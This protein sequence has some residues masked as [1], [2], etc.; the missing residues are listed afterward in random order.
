MTAASP[1]SRRIIVLGSTGSIGVNTL[2]VIE[3]LNRAGTADIQ[4][5]GL[6]AGS[7]A[8][9]LIEQAKRFGVKHVAIADP[10]Q[11]ETVTDALSDATV[12]SGEGSALGLVEEVEATDCAAAIV[13]AAGLPSTLAAIRHGLTIHLSNKETL[14]A[15]G[16]LVRP[17]LDRYGATLIPVD[18]EHSAIFQC[19]GGRPKQQIKR[20]VLTGSGGPFRTASAS[21][22][23][24]ATVEQALQHPTWNMGPKITIDSATL[25]N[26][27]L[28]LIEAHWLF[29]LPGEKIDLL[30]HPESVVHSFV[31]FTDHSILAQLGPPDMRTPIQY[32]LTHPQRL[33][34]C[35]DALDW[36]SLTGLTFEQVDQQRFRAP[37]LGY[38]VIETGGTSG[39]ICN[40]AN[41]AAVQAFLER[42]VPFGRMVDLVAK[43]LD[44]VPSQPADSLEA[45]LD[46]D[47]QGREFVTSRINNHDA[48]SA[49]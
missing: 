19:L 11:E 2:N 38:R 15:A 16:E 5:V 24:E 20:I 37:S 13:G 41:E 46:A 3:H 4:V 34:G 44:Q 43:A 48:V 9:L 10:S 6:A 17:M 30:L 39:A 35:A 23:E 7:N 21:E 42:K 40:G 33:A 47:R 31:E 32:A 49:R 18:S 25:M 1:A 14:V 36:A 27:A 12:F 29:D 22:I 8:G 28:E 45:V 26:K